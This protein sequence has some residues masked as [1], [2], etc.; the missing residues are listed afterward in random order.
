MNWGLQVGRA[1]RR[2]PSKRSREVFTRTR[3]V[4]G[5]VVRMAGALRRARPACRCMGSSRLGRKIAHFHFPVFDRGSVLAMHWLTRI[6]M[7]KSKQPRL[8][9]PEILF[10][11]IAREVSG[12][13]I[14]RAFVLI[15]LCFG[16]FV[17][18]GRAAETGQLGPASLVVE[19]AG[20]VEFQLAGQAEWRA[21]TNGL[22]LRAGDRVRTRAQSRAAVQYSDRS[23]LRL[24]ENTTLEIEPPRT[25]GKRRFRLPVGSIFFFNRERPAEVE[26]DTPVASGAIRGTEFVLEVAG[27]AGLTRL[28]L[29]DGAVD[30]TAAGTVVSLQGGEQARVEP[31]GPPVK[32]PLLEIASVMQWTVYYPAVVDPD[33]LSFTAEEQSRLERALVAYRSGDLLAA[34]AALGNEPAGP[35]APALFQAA[36]NLAVGRV[37]AA[38]AWLAGGGGKSLTTSPGGTLAP[39]TRAVREIVALARNGT[40]SN[41]PSASGAPSVSASARDATPEPGDSAS[42]WLARSYTLQ[43]KFALASARDAARRAVQLA[44]NFGFARVRLAAL[45]MSFEQRTSARAELDRAL[46]L[47]PRLAPAHALVGFIQLEENDPA[48]ALAAFDRAIDIDAGL[49]DAWLGRGLALQRLHRREEAL[50]AFQTAAAVE[51]RRALARSYLGKAFSSAG[52]ARLAEKDFRL[53]RELD[54]GDPTGWLYSALHQ[55]QQN[56]PNRAVR[57]LE[58]SAQLNDQQQ[59]FR[60]RLLLDR[61]RSVRSANQAAIYRDAGLPETGFRAAAAAVQND[62][63]NFSGHLFL[64][65][66]Y[67]AM[68][69]PS[70]YD[71]RFETARLSELLV[72]N[73]LAPVGAGNLSQLLSQQ[74]HLQFFDPRAVGGSFVSEYRSAGDWRQ[75]GTVFGTVDGFAYAVDGAY[76]SQH[77]QEINDHREQFDLSAQFK[78]RLNSRDELYVQTFLGVGH[79]GDVA[80]HYSPDEGIRGL[81]VREEQLPNHFVGWHRTW[82]PAS[83]TL[84]LFSQLRDSFD[85]RN[86]SATVPFLEYYGGEII[87]VSTPPGFAS[88]FSSDFTLY[89]GELQQIWQSERHTVV[90]GARA[91]AGTVESE[92]AVQ[93]TL[94]GTVTE[95][96]IDEP[97]RRANG[98]VYWQGHVAEPL[99]LI[100]GLSYD[101]L[102][103]PRNSELAPLTAGESSRD[104]L[105]PKVG[106]LFNPWLGGLWRAAYTR[107]LGGQFFDNSVRL[108]PAQVAGFTQAYRSLAPE[109]SVGLVP[110]T[111]FDTV[112]VGL[113]QSLPHGT[114]FGVGAEWLHS[115][116]RRT[117]GA[118]TNSLPVPVPDSPSGTRQTLDFRERNLSLY[119]AQLLGDGW[120]VGLRYRVGEASLQTRLPEVPDTAGGLGAFEQNERAVLQQATLS[121]GYQHPMGFF[122]R[123]ESGWWHQ[124]NSG[125]VPE[126]TTE[127]FW[128]HDLWLGWRLPRRQA[129]LRLG[130]LNLF[131]SDYRLNPLSA[132]QALPRGRTAV[133]SLRL[134]F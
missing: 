98:Y 106:V 44:P 50:R 100:A 9:S 88:R 16:S 24:G 60:S 111:I 120:T 7:S 101:H 113:D 45:E 10:R 53:A 64:A 77:G 70:R 103:H 71:L 33:E 131:D 66:S 42:E 126:R 118:L 129:E 93:R 30:L 31:G 8:M 11:G 15:W 21:A 23:V 12:P 115:D 109:S 1:L 99:R 79:G 22:V 5:E 36:V 132:Y 86:L 14:F 114:Y 62:Y 82:S 37:E 13:G 127:D 27:E 61:D 121:L 110:G 25:A 119:F 17:G 94:T 76:A 39:A 122:G 26:F 65:D 20:G 123:W 108:E 134:N 55:W 2:P 40:A 128:Q 84:V 74:E 35:G 107:S 85:L 54:P 47:S 90:A 49:G 130:L 89:S 51:P 32:S 91:Q 28:A 96:R 41:A 4:G 46:M 83:H 87:N 6:W 73:L 78:L 57:E 52:E 95:D 19:V 59:L 29:L 133:V 69:D 68:E 112:S 117:I 38:E 105:A 67:R 3:S 80:R 102:T 48:A 56:R 92:A 75:L 104:L 58:Q 116:G 63:A 124:H 18:S 72:A 81:R 97:L 43:A 125:Y 34:Q